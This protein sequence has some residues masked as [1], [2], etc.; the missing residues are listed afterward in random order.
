MYKNSVSVLRCYLLL[1]ELVNGTPLTRLSSHRNHT[2]KRLSKP[3]IKERAHT[4]Q[5]TFVLAQAG[6]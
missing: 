3:T 5:S 4:C 6:Q 1:F 2:A